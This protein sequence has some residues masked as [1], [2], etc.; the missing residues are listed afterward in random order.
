MSV[1]EQILNDI[2]EA[3][4]SKDNFKR[5]TLRLI[6]SVFKQIEV[7]ERVDLS[8]ERV[9][10]ILQTEIKRRNESATQY[11]AGAREDLADKE[12]NEIAIISSYL[13]KQLND[14]ELEAKM[15]E[16]IAS[17]GANDIKDLGKLMKVAK[18][19]FG[20]SC[21]GKRMSECAKKMLSK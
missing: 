15:K 21:D 5:D 6:N 17:I 3:M 11:K 20:A 18:D 2:K 12:L 1:K 19:E 7:D 4:K 9:F 13:P 8:D 14:E 10:A 16:L